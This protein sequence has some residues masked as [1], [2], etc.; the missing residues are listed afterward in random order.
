MVKF[1]FIRAEQNA[2]CKVV[3]TGKEVNLSDGD[4]TQVPCKLKVPGPRKMVE[5]SFK[6]YS[7]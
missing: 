5:N 2:D 1:Y 7:T 6:K 4:G 3:I